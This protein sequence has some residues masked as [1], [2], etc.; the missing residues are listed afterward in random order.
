M[1]DPKRIRSKYQTPVHPWQKERLEQEK[2]LVQIYGLVNKTEVYKADSKLKKYKNIAKSI[3]TKTGSQA[4]KEKQQLFDKLKS[5]NLV[6]EDSLDAVLGLKLEQLLERRLQTILVKKGLARTSK[7]AR[8]M[9]THRH[10]TVNGKMITSPSYLVTITEENNIN[11]YPGSNFS[12]EEHPERKQPEVAQTQEE[13]KVLDTKNKKK[14]EE[15]QEQ[16]KE[17]NV[18][19]TKDE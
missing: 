6:N 3:V 4:E 17:E 14:T 10:V 18:E 8:Q 12:D 1:G 9:I 19:V 11:F 5:L 16:P 13:K 2:S 15:P 7:Q